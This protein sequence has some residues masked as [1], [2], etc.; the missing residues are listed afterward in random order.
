MILTTLIVDDEEGSRQ[1]LRHFLE[2]YCPAV[3]VIGE[4][5]SVAAAVT[6]I[7]QHEPMLVF[8]DINMP[9]DNGFA[10][11]REI[12]QPRF[13]TI[14]VTAYDHYALQAIRQHALDYILKPV[15]VQDLIAAV[16]RAVQYCSR[17]QLAGRF[18]ELLASLQH[19]PAPKAKIDLPTT[20]GFIYVCID[21]IIRCEAS[22]NYTLFHFT[23]RKPVIVCRNLGHYEMILKDAGF[24]RI[25]H[26]HLIN[27]DHLQ[28]YQ[29][30]RGGTVLMSDNTEL[31]VSQRKR[32][33]FL[34]AIRGRMT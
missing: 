15:N 28:Q 13:Q 22:D 11:F 5:D 24:I 1:T 17:Q 2:R 19:P 10:L 21:N 7:E 34:N 18:D 8:L 25:H 9:K 27:P 20:N 30:G 29:H 32:E 31:N 33:E 26:Q 12:P 4:A 14:F 16:E 6:A 23:D 3:Q